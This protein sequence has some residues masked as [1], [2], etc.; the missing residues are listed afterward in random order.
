MT[1]A[2]LVF[3]V[4]LAACGGGGG[5]AAPPANRPAEPA[6]GVVKDTRSPLEQRRDEACGQLGPKLASCA[7]EDSR[8][9]FEAKKISEQ[10]YREATD[11]KVVEALAAD[12]RKKCRSGYMSSRQVRVL[13]VCFREEQAC[14]PLQACLENLTK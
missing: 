14:A 3:G 7:V 11:P 13:E 2:V 12:W 4:L 5:A 8:A 9:M 1:R 6:P 10:E